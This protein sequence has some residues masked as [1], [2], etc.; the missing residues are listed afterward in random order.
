MTD[1]VREIY[2]LIQQVE[3]WHEPS[4]LNTSLCNTYGDYVEEWIKSSRRTMEENEF[5]RASSAMTMI[6]CISWTQKL[7]SILRRECRKN[8]RFSSSVSWQ[9]YAYNM[10]RIHYKTRRN[11]IYI[12]TDELFHNVWWY[13]QHKNDPFVHSRE[14]II[15]PPR[16]EIRPQ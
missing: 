1:S 9:L 7:S 4:R 11:Y 14:W 12:Y 15:P 8:F 3:E 10:I 16:H 5:G 13:I 2:Y 6:L